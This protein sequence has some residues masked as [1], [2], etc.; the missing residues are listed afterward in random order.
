MTIASFPLLPTLFA[1][2]HQVFAAAPPQFGLSLI[3]SHCFVALMVE[4]EQNCQFGSPPFYNTL[5]KIGAVGLFSGTVVLV[6]VCHFQAIA[7][8]QTSALTSPNL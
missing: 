7:I 5:V 8:S 4:Y 1:F 6:W 2:F 3:P